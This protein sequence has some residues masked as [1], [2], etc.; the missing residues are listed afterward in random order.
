MTPLQMLDHYEYA[1]RAVAV[2]VV[3]CLLAAMIGYWVSDRE[4][5]DE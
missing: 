5:D 3:G 1:C 4:V 2:T